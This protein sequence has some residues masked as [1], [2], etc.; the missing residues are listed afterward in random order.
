MISLSHLLSYMKHRNLSVDSKYTDPAIWNKEV[1][2]VSSFKE[3][4]N[5]PEQQNE[6]SAIV[7]FY[8]K[9]SQ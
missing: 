8:N 6:N 1:M 4:S 9:L 5:T 3:K 7:A 2:R